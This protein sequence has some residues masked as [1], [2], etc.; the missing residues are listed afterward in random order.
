MCLRAPGRQAWGSLLSTA[1]R[2]LIRLRPRT[3][4][5]RVGQSEGRAPGVA[6]GNAIVVRSRSLRVHERTTLPKSS[7][8]PG[9]RARAHAQRQQSERQQTCFWM[10]S[11]C[12]AR[13]RNAGMPPVC[14]ASALHHSRLVSLHGS[15]HGRGLQIGLH[16]RGV[17][18][19]AVRHTTRQ[20]TPSGAATAE[21]FLE[22]PRAHGQTGTGARRQWAGARL[23]GVT[24]HD[25]ASRSHPSASMGGSSSHPNCRVLA[26]CQGMRSSAMRRPSRARRT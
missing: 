25:T 17:Q 15:A 6:Q 9:T 18:L 4:G 22:H 3:P 21:A 2:A 12:R 19:S 8:G 14:C 7:S 23:A 1:V 11:S 5:E 13:R 16:G 24:R 26:P 10:P 20:A